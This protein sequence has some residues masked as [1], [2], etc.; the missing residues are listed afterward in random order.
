[1]DVAYGFGNC[2]AKAVAFRAGCRSEAAEQ[3]V[4]VKRLSVLRRI[5]YTESAPGQRYVDF[6]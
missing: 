5:A 6:S 2:K 4:A 3:P 1:M